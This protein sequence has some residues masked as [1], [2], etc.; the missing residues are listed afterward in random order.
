MSVDASNWAKFHFQSSGLSY[1]YAE[2]KEHPLIISST[3]LNIM[4]S[5]SATE[6]SFLQLFSLGHFSWMGCLSMHPMNLKTQVGSAIYCS[7]LG[8]SYAALFFFQFGFTLFDDFCTVVILVLWIFWTSRPVLFLWLN[9]YLN[10]A[11]VSSHASLFTLCLLP[12]S[13]SRVSIY[14]DLLIALTGL[15]SHWLHT[16]VLTSYWKYAIQWTFLETILLELWV[17]FMWCFIEFE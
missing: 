9:Y 4:F 8:T 6:L 1:C 10:V 11:W 17:Y 3:T 5:V 12:F 13:I 15:A 16:L 2:I 7:H 14:V